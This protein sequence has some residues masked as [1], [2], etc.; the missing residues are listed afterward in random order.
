MEGWRA[1]GGSRWPDRDQ[2]AQAALTGTATALW[3]ALPDH[4]SSRSARVW[5]KTALATVVIAGSLVSETNC[6]G[7]MPS[8]KMSA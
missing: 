3:Y 8:P 6:A 1:T 2:L 4:V 5:I 7:G